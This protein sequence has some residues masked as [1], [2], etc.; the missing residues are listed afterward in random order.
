[1]VAVCASMTEEVREAHLQ[2]RRAR[3][4]NARASMSEVEREARL[5]SRRTHV[6]RLQL[7]EHMM[8]M[9]VPA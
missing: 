1:M 7:G 2:S 3:D 6:A 9:L 8:Q 4:A 5:Q